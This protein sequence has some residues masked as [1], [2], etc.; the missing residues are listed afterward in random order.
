MAR[1]A[2]DSGSEA[3]GLYF[4]TLRTLNKQLV[5]KGLAGELVKRRN[6]AD[7]AIAAAAEAQG[8]A[9]NEAQ[10]AKE[11]IDEETGEVHSA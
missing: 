1:Q 6:A 7:L 11:W 2:A 3:L 10:E 8:E 9:N 5:F 4:K